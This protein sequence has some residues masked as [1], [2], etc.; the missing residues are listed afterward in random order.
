MEPGELIFMED[1]TL[2]EAMSAFEVSAY[3]IMELG[4]C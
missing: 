1:F 4:F 3:H 2:Y